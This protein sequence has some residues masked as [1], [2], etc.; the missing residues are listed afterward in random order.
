MVVVV[1]EESSPLLLLQRALVV[2]AET[3]ARAAARVGEKDHEKEESV[4]KTI[5][6]PPSFMRDNN[7]QDDIRCRGSNRL[8]LVFAMNM[9]GA[10]QRAPSYESFCYESNKI[11]LRSF[12][13]TL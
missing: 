5:A 7:K 2:D 10:F 4:A 13:S 1:V 8:I 6:K 12:T 11:D 9:E 3:K